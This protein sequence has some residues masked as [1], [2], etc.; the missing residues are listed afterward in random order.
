MKSG[1]IQSFL[2]ELKQDIINEIDQQWFNFIC[3]EEN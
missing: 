3:D 1:Y 2:L